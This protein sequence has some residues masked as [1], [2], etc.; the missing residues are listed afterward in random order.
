MPDSQTPAHS[1]LAARAAAAPHGGVSAH[2]A[3]AGGQ[4]ARLGRIRQPRPHHR[5]DAAAGRAE[6]RCR[7]ARSGGTGVDRHDLHRAADGPRRARAEHHLRGRSPRPRAHRQQ[8]RHG[9]HGQRRA[10]AGAPRA[11]RRDRGLR[12]PHPGAGREGGRPGHRAPPPRCGSWC[13]GST[14]HCAWPTCSGR[15]ST[16]R[17]PRSRPSW[18]PT[19]SSRSSSSCTRCWRA[20]CRCSSSRARSSR[21]RRPR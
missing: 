12:P 14:I 6:E 9:D 16:P 15:C 3:A 8:D 18:R 17:P 7:R 20:R 11:R 2:P 21:R 1:V 5:P 13:S 4:P 19:R 10:A